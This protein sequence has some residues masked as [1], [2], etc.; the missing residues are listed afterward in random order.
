MELLG[1]PHLSRR[2][3]GVL[4]SRK[5]YASDAPLGGGHQP[6]HPELG[7]LGWVNLGLVNLVWMNLVLSNLVLLEK[8][9]SVR[10]FC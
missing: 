5:L 7:T 3:G 1:E 2:Y 10:L 4:K 9:V 6:E 8:L